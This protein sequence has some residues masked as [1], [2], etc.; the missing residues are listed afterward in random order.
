MKRG[1]N[2]R[3]WKLRNIRSCYKGENIQITGEEEGRIIF[4]PRVQGVWNVEFLINVSLELGFRYKFDARRRLLQ[5]PWSTIS[6]V[7]K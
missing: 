2:L 1:N 7:V 4:R 3:V 6:F 5:L